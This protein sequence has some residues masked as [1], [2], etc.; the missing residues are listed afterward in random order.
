MPG[1]LNPYLA[2]SFLAGTEHRSWQQEH[3]WSCIS[4]VKK[5]ATTD[6]TVHEVS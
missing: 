6:G 5:K 4:L 1:S 3:I 2:L